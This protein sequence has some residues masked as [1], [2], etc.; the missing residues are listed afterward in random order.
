MY[1]QLPPYVQKFIYDHK[2]EN[3]RDI[4]VKAFE[5]IR[6]EENNVI[7]AAGTASGKTEA[8]FFPILTE[9]YDH[10]SNSVGVLYI[11]PL[12]ALINDQFY[13]LEEMLVNGNIPLCKWHGD[14]S[15]AKKQKLLDSPAGIL[16]ITGESLEMLLSHRENACRKLFSDLRYII[17]DEMHYFMDSPRG[18]QLLCL[19]ERLQRLLKH[20]PLRIGL[21]ATLGDYDI[22][23]EWLCSGSSKGY[24]VVID[25]SQKKKVGV[26]LRSFPEKDENHAGKMLDYIY[27]YTCRHKSIIFVNRRAMAE[28]VTIEMKRRAM[29]FGNPD[30][31]QIHHGSI[32]AEIREETETRMKETEDPM[33][34]CATVTL[35]LGIDIGKLDRIVQI[36]SPHSVSSFAQRLGRC[37]RRGQ[38]ADIIYLPKEGKDDDILNGWDWDLLKAVAILQLY[39]KEKWVEPIDLKKKPFEILYHQTMLEL[40]NHGEQKASVLASRILTLAPFR[41]ITQNEYKI[42]LTHLLKIGHIEKAGTGELRLTEL[43]EKMTNSYKFSAVFEQPVEYT[44][45][46]ENQ[47]LG[48][49]DM[50]P[51]PGEVLVLAGQAWKCI[52][53]KE[54]TKEVLVMRENSAAKT[55]WRPKPYAGIHTKVMR[56]MRQIVLCEEEYRY[57]D[58]LSTVKLE[59]MRRT[60]KAFHMDTQSILKI[61]ENEYILLLWLGSKQLVAIF[62]ALASIGYSISWPK[63]YYFCIHTKYADQ[64]KRDVERI[65]QGGL[66]KYS[67]AYPEDITLRNKYNRYMPQELTRMEYIEDYVDYEGATKAY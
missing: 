37:G 8:A 50:L 64:L 18:I 22:A 55:Y 60:S 46:S 23:G 62:Y 67:F 66:D 20:E 59:D 3:F 52:E 24:Q 7:L 48:A 35:E 54:K 30:Q 11:S 53:V 41:N 61:A 19:L 27:D 34:I 15:Q 32:S 40:C 2:W 29:K 26:L 38:R 10:P 33:I 9:L 6:K 1:N 49:V 47:I 4:Q 21:S 13:R 5:E 51:E 31:Y 14:V 25:V 39:L 65:L 43:G 58:T 12:K 44:V 63:A 36:G 56:M 28:F 16:Q 57:L 42:L 45:K 17:I